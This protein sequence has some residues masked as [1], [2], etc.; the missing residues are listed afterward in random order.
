[1]HKHVAHHSQGILVDVFDVVVQGMPILRKRLV[2][3]LWLQVDDID[4]RNARDLVHGQ[5][6]VADRIAQ[7]VD[8]IALVA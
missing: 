4:G 7:F 5:M 1:M 6:V 8:E 3:A 2:G